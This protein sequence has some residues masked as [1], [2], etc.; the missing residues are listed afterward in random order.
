MYLNTK[1][2]IFFP[3]ALKFIYVIYVSILYSKYVF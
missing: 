1:C 2:I 3:K